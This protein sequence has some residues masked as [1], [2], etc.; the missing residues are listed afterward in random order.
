MI[1]TCSA[2]DKERKRLLAEFG[3]L[4]SMTQNSINFEAIKKDEKQ[5]CQFVL[6]PSSPSLPNGVSLNDP[7]ITQFYTLSREYGFLLDKTAE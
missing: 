4:C 7:L 3:Y 6:D 2:V 5:L 1:S